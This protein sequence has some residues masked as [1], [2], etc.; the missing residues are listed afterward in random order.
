MGQKRGKSEGSFVRETRAQTF[1]YHRDIVQQL[2]P[3]RPARGNWPGAG[4]AAASSPGLRRSSGRMCATT[5]ADPLA[6]GGGI[7]TPSRR[8]AE[9]ATAHQIA[10]LHPAR[11]RRAVA[12]AQSR[13]GVSFDVLTGTR[14]VLGDSHYSARLVPE[15]RTV[16]VA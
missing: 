13:S 6:T 8:A 1:D 3:G 11:C 2:K 16:R 9:R 5:A 10:P 4:R 12:C 7:L 15:A 14:A